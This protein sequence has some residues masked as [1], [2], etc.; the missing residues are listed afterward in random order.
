MT[1][2]NRRVVFLSP[3]EKRILDVLMDTGGSNRQIAEV[4]GRTEDTVKGQF[5]TLYTKTGCRTRTELVVTVFRRR[6]RLI[7]RK[8]RWEP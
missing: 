8:D 7:A 4:L 5:R 3:A 6:V 2:D 1:E